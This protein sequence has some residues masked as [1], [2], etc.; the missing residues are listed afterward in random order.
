MDGFV[1]LMSEGFHDSN[2]T[3][4]EVGYALA[5]G[6][7]IIAVRLGR[8]PYGFLGKFQALA[9]DWAGAPEE[10]VKVLIRNDRMLSAFIKALR[11][12]QNFDNGNM[13]SRIL[14]IIKEVSDEQIDDMID[15]FN[16]NNELIGSFGFNGRKWKNW[17]HGL[18]PHLHR[19]GTRRYVMADVP[20]RIEP[21]F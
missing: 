12:C 8:D 17:G 7:P 21:D 14:P 4:Q 10:I 15:A 1:A 13:L 3:D 5:R 20:T 16:G 9:S 2:W 18:L 19:W 11:R 6:V